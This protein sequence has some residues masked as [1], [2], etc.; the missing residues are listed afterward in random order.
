MG[1][2][3]IT[4]RTGTAENFYFHKVTAKVSRNNCGKQHKD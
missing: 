1:N 2:M 4:A 3:G